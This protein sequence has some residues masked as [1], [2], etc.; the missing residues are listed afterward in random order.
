[1]AEF[2][3]G[4]LKFVWKG[5]WAAASVYVKDD[6]I[7][8]GGKSYV[9]VFGHTAASNFYDDS[10]DNYWEEMSDGIT[11]KN[12]WDQ[13]TWYR[14]ND[15]VRFGGGLYICNTPHTS[16]A[17]FDE[18]KWDIFVEGYEYENSWSN[19]LEYQMGDVVAYG[20]YTYKALRRNTDKEPTQETE[21]WVPFL[22]GI[23][24]SGTWS[25]GS[26]KVGDIVMYGGNTYFCTSDANSTQSPANLLFWK[27]YSEGFKWRGPWTNGS[28]Y[29]I[30]EVVKKSTNSYI[31]VQHHTAVLN[32]NDP[33]TDTANDYWEVLAD[34]SAIT[35]LTT[36][37]DI[38][39][40]DNTGN[41]RLPIS[42]QDKILAVGPSNEPIWTNT[43]NIRGTTLTT[44]ADITANGSVIVDAA[45]TGGEL[46]IG[47]EAVDLTVDA[48]QYSGYTGLTDAKAV[49]DSNVNAF[50]QIALKNRNQ[51]ILASTDL[52][53]YADTGDNASGWIDM[54]ITSK[55]F[56]ITSGYGIT[57][58][59]DG[60][61][62][63]SAPS[64]TTGTGNL[65]IAT[66]ENG[67]ERDIIFVTGGFDPSINTDAEKVRIIGEARNGATFTGS[68]SNTTLT[69]TS[70][71]GTIVYNGT[72][73]ITG[74]DILDGTIILAQLTGTAGGN[75]T[76][77]V[78]QKQTVSSTAGLVQY[79]KTAGLEV[80]IDTE[81]Y[82]E[83]TG[84]LRVN[85]GIG[86]VG[87]LNTQGDI[88]SYG[89]AL[90]QGISSGGIS[91]KQLSADDSVFT[92]YVGLTDASG[93]FTGD[94]DAFVQFALKNHNS[95]NSASTD[96]ICYSS[97]GDNDSG[98]VD[99]GITSSTFADPNF[100]VTG[101][102]TG[103]LFMAAPSEGISTR[104]TG[105][106]TSSSTTINVVS[107]AAFPTSGTCVIAGG[108]Q[109]TYT[110]KTS[111]SFTGCT[112]GANNSTPNSIAANTRIYKAS[113][114][115]YTG[116]LLIGTGTGGSH[117][118]IVL[119]SG[120]F[121]AGNERIRIIGNT[122]TGHAAGVEILAA[123]ESSSS[124][125][126]A[127]RVSGGIGLVGNMNVGGNITINGTIT[128][129]GGGSS[130]STTTLTVSDPMIVMGS[131]NSADIIDLGFYGT[132][133]SSGTKYAGLVRDATDGKFKLFTALASAP[134]T[135]VN[136]TTPTYGDLFVGALTASGA[137]SATGGNVDLGASGYTVN[138]GGTSTST[139]T[140]NVQNDLLV[141][142][143]KVIKIGASEVLAKSKLTLNGSSSGTVAL[144]AAASAG[145]TTFTLPA[146]DGTSG[147][148]LVTNASGVLSFA[149]VTP[150]ASDDT[151]TNSSYY[152]TFITATTGNVSTLK[153]SSTK[154]TF[155]PSTGTL[156]STILT[157]SSDERLKENVVPITSALD[158]V[159][160][161][162]GV[163]FNRIGQT[164]KE[165]GVIAQRVEE[166]IPELV[167]TG[168][169]G[170]KSVAYGNTVAV[171][172]EAI[173]EQQA[174]IEALK[175]KLG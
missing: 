57:G 1:M 167:V 99:I 105:T 67:S 81:S 76:Y 48:S 41:A 45:G 36:R 12:Q 145:S 30:N 10:G 101:P 157:A 148:A 126:G 75:G 112:R 77:R 82:N 58:K 88:I 34:G 66:G 143:G 137:L 59:H 98:W 175:A 140:I 38:L 152:P 33:Q 23:N 44:T 161:L 154:L 172:I 165:I 69:I 90:Y 35:T 119:F 97:G 171:L 103:Y 2:K 21:D 93:I 91:A 159:L 46:Y 4:R 118:D 92:G 18:T 86:L 13:D 9:C 79:E 110:G 120:G 170:M 115:T 116:D 54:G 15:F 124:T 28:S 70:H 129:A 11:W 121:D 40:R 114:A 84:A 111:T 22:E 96:M 156:T 71:T 47:G 8:Y 32:T 7:K 16:G 20:G 31:C 72:G 153:V 135:T 43:A 65:V 162:Q 60:Y 131:G 26:Y 169:D 139:A 29:K 3:L 173:K 125:T 53:A 109:F 83:Y 102:N 113:S 14:L 50:A 123:T 27:L 6:I 74:G 133:T 107:T 130:V 19:L 89:G 134:T 128:V 150:A 141:A 117:N 37:G 42:T 73:T 149:T 80:Y 87:N 138:I 51:G 147:Q 151:T 25:A 155:N 164:S 100:T 56:D 168:E 52:I 132:Y 106:H 136:F 158:K 63:M 142:A 94:N 127:L 64:T 68:I 166:V 144:Q 108:G 122:R 104:S 78:N 5:D 17:D 85:G 163:E 174:Q 62:F 49:F 95:G 61:I 160:R 146:A 24:H 39:F 55:N